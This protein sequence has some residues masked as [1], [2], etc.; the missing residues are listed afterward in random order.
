MER[1]SPLNG[2]K[3][4]QCIIYIASGVDNIA[5]SAFTEQS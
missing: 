1:E 2:L 4:I 3:T 5:I